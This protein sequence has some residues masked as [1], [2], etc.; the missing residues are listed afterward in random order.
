MTTDVD[1]F[2]T[3]VGV[4]G[5]HWGVRR[6]KTQQ[7]SNK[8]SNAKKVAAGVGIGVAVVAG[9]A[10]AT[11][12]LHNHGNV[13]V[14]NIPKPTSKTVTSNAKLIESLTHNHN[15]RV[16]ELNNE[17]RRKDNLLQIPFAQRSYLQGFPSAV[18]G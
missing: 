2:L 16:R 3:H 10:V 13:K 4:K 14:S 7:D 9:A 6:G 18:R 12:L 1:E 11:A 8:K 17:L 5:M 15:V